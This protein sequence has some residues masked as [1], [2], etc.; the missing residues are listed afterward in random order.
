MIHTNQTWKRSLEETAVNFFFLP[1]VEYA[2]GLAWICIVYH[3]SPILFS[4]LVEI[5]W[6]ISALPG[7]C[8]Q[9][10]AISIYCVYRLLVSIVGGEKLLQVEI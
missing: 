4:P 1:V 8:K 3:S 5:E 6:T 2:V 10:I 7:V 9:F